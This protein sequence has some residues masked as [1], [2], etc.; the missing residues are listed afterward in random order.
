MT[1]NQCKRTHHAVTFSIGIIKVICHKKIFAL[2]KTRASGRNVGKV[3]NPVVKLVLENQPFLI[4]EPAEKLSL[5]SYLRER[6]GS[7]TQ[8]LVR[9]HER[10][11]H[12]R[13]CC[14][15]HHIFNMRCRDEG[16]YVT[17][18]YTHTAT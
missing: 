15:N 1:H 7:S 3:F 12:R 13:A 18:H 5:Y 17:S 9:E 16:V 11:L 8:K 4:P 6:Y 10:S 2:K 14:G